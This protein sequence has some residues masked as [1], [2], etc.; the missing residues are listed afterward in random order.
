M[1]LTLSVDDRF[2]YTPARINP[3]PPNKQ[4][5]RLKHDYE[6]PNTIRL[7]A[8]TAEVFRLSPFYSTVLTEKWQWFCFDLIREMVP[9][10]SFELQAQKWRAVYN[11]STAFTNGQGFDADPGEEHHANY[12]TGEDLEFSDPKIFTLICGGNVISGVEVGSYL[13]VETLDGKADPPV[14]V[15]RAT[16]PWLIQCGTI[17]TLIKRSDGTNKVIRFP[18]LN[19]ADVLVPIVSPYT[20][21]YPLSKLVKLPLGSPVPSPYNFG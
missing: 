1:T 2:T 16:H 13:V 10:W 8:P 3:V 4:L 17:I 14:G 5:Y 7:T 20:V 9:D 12:I 19:G 15:S 18:H 21:L 6:Y 11:N